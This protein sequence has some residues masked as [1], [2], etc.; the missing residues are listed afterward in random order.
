ME[1]KETIEIAAT[2]VLIFVLL[3]LITNSIK[4]NRQDPARNKRPAALLLKKEQLPIDKPKEKDKPV[5][6][7]L[8][9]E[10]KNWELKRDPF[11][12]G[13]AISADVSSGLYLDGILWDKEKPLA[14]ISGNIVKRGDKIGRYLVMEI[15]PAGVVLDDGTND[16][17]LR[18]GESR[19]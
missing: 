6:R 13:A 9:E 3:I 11:S 4:N 5:Y 1:K 7:I 16:F 10:S 2:A 15:K 18:V 8:E 19:E 12:A 14:I 17:E